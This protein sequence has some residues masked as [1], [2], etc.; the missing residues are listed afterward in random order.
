MVYLEVGI[1][2]TSRE[3]NAFVFARKMCAIDDE[4]RSDVAKTMDGS[5]KRK[6]GIEETG[7]IEVI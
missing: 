3:E 2:A 1:L 5:S 4:D 7:L 6:E